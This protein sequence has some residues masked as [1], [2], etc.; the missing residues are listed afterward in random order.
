MAR[1]PQMHGSTTSQPSSSTSSEGS[2]DSGSSP[3]PNSNVASIT[4]TSPVTSLH[5]SGYVPGSTMPIT[6]MAF[7]SMSSGFRAVRPPPM[8]SNPL[9]GYVPTPTTGFQSLPVSEPERYTSP[10]VTPTP[11]TT[12]SVL[13]L[14]QQMDES[15]AVKTGGPARFGPAHL[16]FGLRRAGLKKPG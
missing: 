12:A 10:R 7:H 15:R 13:S 14:R 8:A 9:Y 4:S 16:G 5:D 1:T 3:P 6:T 11:L 2:P